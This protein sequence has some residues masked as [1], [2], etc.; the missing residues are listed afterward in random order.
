MRLA[1]LLE[2]LKLGS[3]GTL[4]GSKNNCTIKEKV[5]K[6]VVC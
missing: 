1:L 3:A 5:S 2:K 4:S 6:E